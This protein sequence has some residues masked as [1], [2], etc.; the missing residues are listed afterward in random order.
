MCLCPASYARRAAGR[1]SLVPRFPVAFRPAGICLSGHPFPPLV[2][3]GP[4]L[5]SA[6]RGSPGPRQGFHVPHSPRP[7]RRGC[8]LYPEATVFPRPA[9]ARRPPSPLPNGRPCPQ[10]YIP[11]P[12][13]C[14]TRHQRGYRFRSP[15]RSS[16]CLW[17]P[18]GAGALGLLPRCFGP[19]RCQRRTSGWGRIT[20]TSP[21][22]TDVYI[23]FLQSVLSLEAVR[24]RVASTGRTT[25]RTAGGLPGRWRTRGR[26]P[27]DV[28]CGAWPA[29]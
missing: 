9:C 21:E 27:G 20:N 29:T 18:Y 19:R 5:R 22:L 15:V 1:S 12:G 11:S 26:S 8:P 6:Y 2:G 17:P 23:P 14:V 4:S 28:P 25:R 10:H 13:V 24:L 16:P 7:D 3:V